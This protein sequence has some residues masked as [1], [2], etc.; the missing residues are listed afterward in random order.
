MI[1]LGHV[2][3]VLFRRL[4]QPAVIGEMVAGII[5]GPSVLGAFAPE[6]R[7][8]LMPT[9]ELDPSG[10]VLSA[11]KA[12]AQLGI[13]LYMFLV[14]LEL[15]THQ[16]GRQA[17]TAIAI[18]HASIVIPF[19]LGAGLALWLYP[20][21][22]QS[23]VAFT[24]FS[25]FLGV[26][27]SITAFPVLARILSD[28][29][30]ERTELGTVALSCAASDD[31]T[32]WCL[33]AFVVGIAQARVESAILV[34]IWSVVF[35]GLMLG[36][37]RPLVRRGVAWAE[38]HG[39][40][41]HATPCLLVAAFLAALTTEVIGIHAVFG[42]FLM[43]AVI[44]HDSR[45]AHQIR[46]QLHSVVTMLLLP[47]FFAISGFQTRIDLISGGY[48]WLICG[49]I[50]AVATVGKFGATLVA[51]RV[52]GSDWRTATALGVLMNTRGL[53]ELIVLNIGLGLGVISPR[54][55]AMMVIM[56][57][58]TTLATA[59]LLRWLIPEADRS[60]A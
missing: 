55:Y 48:D 15:N 9:P 24:S 8:W 12:I 31:V 21:L 49:A 35:I 52:T 1:A 43:G 33:L 45:I 39:L 6:L 27:M 22:S 28:Q 7:E 29:R 42:A 54:L 37:I 23:D 25:L 16:V 38:S 44:P 59:P 34:L 3:A 19:V 51:A 30:L 40:D 10:Q 60:P 32:A 4:G 36:L 5:L 50:I 47:A 41:R 46:E 13:V 57:L 56:A 58:V 18:S 53:M 20:L 26:A 17:H 14:G 11:L 2:L